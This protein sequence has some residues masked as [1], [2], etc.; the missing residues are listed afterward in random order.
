MAGQLPKPKELFHR[1]PD[2]RIAIIASMWHAQCVD[3]MVTRATAELRAV[4]VSKQNILVH[5]LPGSLELPYA[6]SVLFKRFPDLDAI[7]AFGVVLQGETSHDASVLQNVTN[8]F[9]AVSERFGNPIINEVIGVR[10]IEDAE[11][12]SGE[13]D[14]NKGLEAVFAVSELLNWERQLS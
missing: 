7:L 2:A 11:K 10:A 6:A 5:R 12:R 8:G 4:G 13:T 9:A 14:W 3:G 1:I